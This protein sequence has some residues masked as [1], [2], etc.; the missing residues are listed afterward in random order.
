MNPSDI[1]EPQTGEPARIS[2]GRAVTR[3]LWQLLRGSPITNSDALSALRLAL[4]RM[5]WLGIIWDAGPNSEADYDDNRYWIRQITPW[6]SDSDLVA[7]PDL[8]LQAADDLRALWITATNLSECR[9]SLSGGLWVAESKGTRNLTKGDPVEIR[10]CHSFRSPTVPRYYMIHPAPAFFAEITGN[11]EVVADYQWKYSWQEVVD[12]GPG[13]G[14]WEVRSG[15]R[16]GTLNAWNLRENMNT[17]DD[18][19]ENQFGIDI[20]TRTDP[21]ATLTCQPVVIGQIVEMKRTWYLSEG[22]YY[23]KYWFHDPNS[24]DVACEY[25]T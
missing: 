17:G 18:A 3:S 25:S 24:L 2:W 9:W 1:R 16:T 6:N 5:P 7:K 4:M 23:S 19:T 21:P 8:I 13:Y 15:G 22:T 20:G 10:A 11:E 14:N 12:A